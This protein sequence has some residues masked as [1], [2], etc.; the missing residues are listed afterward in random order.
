[1][2]SAAAMTEACASN[3]L[4]VD[5][6]RGLSCRA[7]WES[8]T[9]KPSSFVVVFA[10]VC[11]LLTAMPGAEQGQVL[12]TQAKG[13]AGNAT[14]GDAAGFPVRLSEPGSYNLASNLIPGS[15]LNGIVVAVPMLPSI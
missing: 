12:I 4:A 3:R 1:M 11:V 15:N 2:P 14:P 5:P 13:L 7:A 6:G 10:A 8:S 9:S